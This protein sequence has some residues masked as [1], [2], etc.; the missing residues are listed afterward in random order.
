MRREHQIEL[1]RLG[2]S[3]VEAKIYLALI[4]KGGDWAASAV[5]AAMRIPRSTV[6]LALNSL[7][8][9]GLVESEA[10]YGGRYSAISPEQA[11]PALV[12]REREELVQR[13][14][15]LLE[16]EGVAQQ[17]ATELEPQ[18]ESSDGDGETE[19]IQVLRDPR[20]ATERF[21]RLQREARYAIDGFVKHPI[22]TLHQSNPAQSAAMQR[23]VRY[24]TIY[25]QAVLDAPEVKPYLMKW[26]NGGEEA[27]V[28]AG[29]LPH[30]LMIFDSRYILLPLVTPARPTR[31]LFIRHP[32]LGI[33]LGLLFD[34]FWN[35]STPIA[36]LKAQPARSRKKKSAQR[37][38]RG[39][40][41]LHNKSLEMNGNARVSDQSPV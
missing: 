7:L 36:P 10:G 26:V 41:D 13:E 12:R 37:G 38:G 9:M 27:R 5:A 14:R 39:R 16:R 35:K 28:Y 23:G 19:L 17:L 30:K 34:T 6:Y 3:P 31:T 2:L 11:L 40:A 21:E 32:Q 15:D 1:E 20:V 25:E 8:D 4:E 22:F 18:A 29:E 24:R 33:S